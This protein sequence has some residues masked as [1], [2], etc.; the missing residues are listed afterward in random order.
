MTMIAISKV[1]IAG[2]EMGLRRAGCDMGS[3]TLVWK[4]IHV[5]EARRP[6]Q[7]VFRAA[8]V[9]RSFTVYS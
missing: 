2:V 3:Q 1:S 7:M 6:T 8:A 5:Y 4:K 9:R